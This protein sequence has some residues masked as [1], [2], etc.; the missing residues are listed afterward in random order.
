MLDKANEYYDAGTDGTDDDIQM[1]R[2]SS[3]QMKRARLVA[4]AAQ[5]EIKIIQDTEVGLASDNDSQN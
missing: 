5:K 3:V 2:R 1:L 4:A